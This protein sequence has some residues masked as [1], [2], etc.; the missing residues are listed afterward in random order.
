[1]I[2]V[3]GDRTIKF[4]LLF[5]GRLI[6]GLGAEGLI[7][8][9]S[10]MLGR[11][12]KGH[13]LALSFGISQTIVQVGGSALAFYILPPMAESSGGLAS[14][15]WFTL[16]CHPHRHQHQLYQFNSLDRIDGMCWLIIRQ[17]YL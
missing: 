14:A 10:Q 12:Y 7:Y 5:S 2:P 8:A 3:G 16:V 9:Q 13:A 1:L 17:Y 6:F 15:R 11:W 4:W